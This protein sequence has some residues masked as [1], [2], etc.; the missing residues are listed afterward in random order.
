M[1]A[2]ESRFSYIAYDVATGSR[3]AHGGK[4]IEAL[5]VADLLRPFS[6]IEILYLGQSGKWFWEKN[7]SLKFTKVM[8]DCDSRG[9]LS[10]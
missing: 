9:N 10:A 3:I 5:D 2:K 6:A 7:V 8:L 4:A 1:Y